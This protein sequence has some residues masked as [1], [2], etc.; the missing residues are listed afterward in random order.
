M[1]VYGM[2]LTMLT[3]LIVEDD[4]LV[5]MGTAT[6]L[7]DLGHKPIEVYSGREALAC[8]NSRS[9]IDLVITD[10]GMPGMSGL[11]L[12]KSIRAIWPKLPIILATGYSE[13]PNSDNLDLP[14]LAKPFPQE[15]LAA[16]IR[17]VMGQPDR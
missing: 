12:A 8:L 2:T 14:R 9:D 4:V 17:D 15:D 11:E 10:Q 1:F 5:S 3:V 7:E 6:M 16:M 13:L